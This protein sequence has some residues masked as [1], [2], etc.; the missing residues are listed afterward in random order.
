MLFYPRHAMRVQ[1]LTVSALEKLRTLED[2]RPAQS[3]NVAVV[4]GA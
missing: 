4:R 2:D 3:E 1:V